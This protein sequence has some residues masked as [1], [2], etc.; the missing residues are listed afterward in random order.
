MRG[1][2]RD[3]DYVNEGRDVRG[4][5]DLVWVG[6]TANY[7]AKLS[8]FREGN[9]A[10]WITTGVYENMRDSVKFS[11]DTTHLWAKNDWTACKVEVYGST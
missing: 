11:K 9:F 4:S 2:P 10:T 6:R 5:N 8:G 7:A 1:R 3:Y